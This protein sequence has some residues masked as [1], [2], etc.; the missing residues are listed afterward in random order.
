MPALTRQRLAWF[1]A[2][3]NGTAA[4]ALAAARSCAERLRSTATVEQ[5][6]ARKLQQT[7]FPDG[8]HWVN[9]SVAQGY[10]GLALLWAQ[11]DACFPDE[12]WDRV[13][14]EHLTIAGR[15]L[16]RSNGAPLGIFSGLT[17]MAF[18]AWQLSRGGE[19]YERLLQS[20]DDAVI[21]GTLRLADSLAGSDGCRMSDFDAISGLA[22]IGAYLL[23]RAT[24]PRIH[25]CQ[26]T[27]LE[28]LTALLLASDELP[29]WHTPA[30]FIHDER[31]KQMFS[32]GWLNCGLAHGIPGPLATLSLAKLQGAEI[33]DLPKAI[34]RIGEWLCANRYDDAYGVNWPTAVPLSRDESGRVRQC[35][36]LTA[37]DG[38]SRAAWCY[39][40]PGVARSLWLAGKAAGRQDF[41]DLAVAAMDAIFRRP[42]DKRFIDSPSF[43]HGVAG[44][45]Q[46]T[47]RFAND[48]RD[49]R[50]SHPIEQLVRQILNS[51]SADSLLGFRHLEIPGNEVDQAGFLDG[52]G[53]I[54]AVLLA[55]STD[56]EPAW[57]RLFLLS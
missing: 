34:V 57:D 1:P 26:T 48:L 32:D 7:A 12:G 13:G 55:A 28:R 35:S 10:A 52:A 33:C 36:A 49:D 54:A 20:L 4:R 41:C 16:E 38:P 2:V 46:I 15:D 50:F 44:L 51:Y 19:R 23:K 45:L 53:G 9:Y 29:A 6:V 40:A 42:I 39:G 37:P 25:N 47:L 14:H 21:S 30:A 22:G 5:A 3:S 8:V 18:A 31:T 27:L 17:G 56:V 43:C 11:M 24:E